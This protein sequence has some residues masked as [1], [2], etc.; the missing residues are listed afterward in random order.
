MTDLDLARRA[1]ACRDWRWM[2]G[3]ATTGDYR[4]TLVSDDQQWFI[5]CRPHE[6]PVE[7][8]GGMGG[9][10]PDLSDPA[11]IGCLLQ[12]AREAWKSP[13]LQVSPMLEPA[14]A[15]WVAYPNT[16]PDCARRYV[17]PTEAAALVAA[18]EAAP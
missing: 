2:P 3:M 5:L 7:R 16:G 15:E 13:R 14:P 12:L 10:L 9:N 18:L 8:E 17:A 1:V 11:T 6:Y 4:L